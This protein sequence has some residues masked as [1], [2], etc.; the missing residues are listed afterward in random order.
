MDGLED[1]P[2]RLFER[3]QQIP[4]YTWDETKIFHTPYDN[5]YAIIL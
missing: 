5:W 4:G 2:A 1:P 3:L